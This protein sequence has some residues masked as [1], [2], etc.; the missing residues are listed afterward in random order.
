MAD[1]ST[2]ARRGLRIDWTFI[3]PVVALGIALALK[4]NDSLLAAAGVAIALL[5]AVLAAVHHAEV[6]AARVGDPFGAVVLA[7]AV[8]VIELGLIVSILLGPHPEPT[9]VRD[10]IHAVVILVLHGLAGLCIVVAA[11]RHIEG[12]F[13]TEGALAYLIVLL[14]MVAITLVLP[15]FTT[16]APGPYYTATQLAFVSITCLL[17]WLAFTFIQTVR[18]REHFL[19]VGGTEDAANDEPHGPPPSAREA[20]VALAM[21]AVALVAV[22]LSAKGVSPLL[23]TGVERLGAPTALVGVIVA[24]IVLMPEAITALRAARQDRL[25][26]SINIALGSAVASIGLTVPTVAAIA[27]YTG[28]RLEL[29]VSARD[30]VLLTLSFMMAIITYGTGRASLLSGVVHLILMATWLFLVIA[31]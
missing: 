3:A 24:A 22:V 16:S 13:R 28:T 23:Q 6:V 18:H 20:A 1:S 30:A 17:L 27:W 26:T 12:Q 11:V 4:G 10:T 2:A 7:L 14:P 25:Q 8:T 21:L 29:G 15:N 5:A 9:L 19:P 31:P